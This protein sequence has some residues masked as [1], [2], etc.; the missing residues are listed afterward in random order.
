MTLD[1]YVTPNSFDAPE[2]SEILAFH[3]RTK[4][5]PI[6][7]MSAFLRT[8]N[9]MHSMRGT[10]EASRN[11]KVAPAAE[12]ELLDVAL[13]ERLAKAIR[14]RRS[15]RTFDRAAPFDR[16]GLLRALK[17]CMTTR[18]AQSLL[19]ENI[20]FKFRAYPSAGGLYPVEIHLLEP[21]GEG[22]D[23]KHFDAN[24]G[25]L[26]MMRKAIPTDEIE[27]ALCIGDKTLVH[28]SRG[29]L[30]LSAVWERTVVKYGFAGYRFAL[31]EL[32]LVSQH[33]SLALADQGIETL[34]WAAFFDDRGTDLIGADPRSE[35][36]GYVIWYGGAAS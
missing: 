18:Q 35:T 28:S 6:S 27:N 30:L 19:D 3:D 11:Y 34:H 14:Q 9:Y 2:M 36:L 25:A 20:F 5:K 31:M 8:G 1:K 26:R 13:P 22:F 4:L 33:L 32:G 23:L 12:V 16:T 29:V 17:A 15:C 24:A 21:A 7:S 10:Q